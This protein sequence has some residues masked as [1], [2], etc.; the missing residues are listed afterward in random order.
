VPL[1]KIRDYSL[2]CSRYIYNWGAKI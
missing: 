2:N 1:C